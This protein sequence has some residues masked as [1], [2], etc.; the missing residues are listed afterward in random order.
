MMAEGFELN[1]QLGMHFSPDPQ[2]LGPGIAYPL[3]YSEANERA[4]LQTWCR[5]LMDGETEREEGR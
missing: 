1:L 2:W 5:Y 3:D 4:F